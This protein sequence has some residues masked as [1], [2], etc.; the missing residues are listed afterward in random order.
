MEHDTSRQAR[1][2]SAFRMPGSW[3]ETLLDQHGPLILVE[4]IHCNNGTEGAGSSL[5]FVI[6]YG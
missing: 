2:H 6:T 3:C 1:D 5:C 4:V